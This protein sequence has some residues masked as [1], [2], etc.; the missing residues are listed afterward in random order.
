MSTD[1]PRFRQ[2][3]LHLTSK[4]RQHDGE[5]RGAPAS[6]GLYHHVETQALVDDDQALVD[7]ADASEEWGSLPSTAVGA[8]LV[9]PAAASSSS[10]SSAAFGRP[11]PPA[12]PSV[13]LPPPPPDGGAFGFST[14]H[15]QSGASSLC[16]P[17]TPSLA[18]RRT[19]RVRRRCAHALRVRLGSPPARACAGAVQ[20][21]QTH[22]QPG[23]IGGGGYGGFDQHGTRR[24]R[25][26]T[27][28][29][30]RHTRAS[31]SARAAVAKALRARICST[32]RSCVWRRCT[33]LDAPMLHH[34]QL[35]FYGGGGGYGGGGSDAPA[36]G[37]P[38]SISGG[39]PFECQHESA[40]PNAFNNM[41][42]S[43]WGAPA[44]Q[45]RLFPARDERAA[46]CPRPRPCA[47]R[48][49]ALTRR[50]ALSCSLLARAPA[51]QPA[52]LRS[53]TLTPAAPGSPVARHSRSASAPPQARAFD[54]A[55]MHGS[56]R[57]AL[58][59]TDAD[60]RVPEPPR[61]DVH[62]RRSLHV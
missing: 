18:A 37:G 46:A 39:D 52:T 40:A 4:K 38:A 9:A 23:G 33:G 44:K 48:A 30:S 24:R 31:S 34:H 11:R 1:A 35:D 2:T 7:E 60:G 43:F 16:A 26:R 50:R 45:P 19:R 12:P 56:A 32:P 17:A 57:M 25:A 53:P 51:R 20:H 8:G 41:M 13:P 5:C 10:S 55:S 22:D 15:S 36:D 28:R 6:A 21:Y 42:M 59:A 62:A 49:L 14:S 54:L 58:R 61:C 27:A 29:D 47:H 3:R